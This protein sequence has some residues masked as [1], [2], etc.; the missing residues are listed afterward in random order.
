MAKALEEEMQ[1]YFLQLTEAEKKSVIQMLKTFLQSRKNTNQR[2]TIDIYNEE[3][4]EAMKR[5]DV[6]NSLHKKTWKKKRKNGKYFLLSEHSAKT[7]FYLYF[8]K[9]LL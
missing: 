9:L 1:N 2:I 6:G 7:F 5:I 8:Q 3:I 4:I